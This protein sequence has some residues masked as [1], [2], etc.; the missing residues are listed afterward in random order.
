MRVVGLTGVYN[1][2]SGSYV[3]LIKS[4]YTG[5]FCYGVGLRSYFSRIHGTACACGFEDPDEAWSASQKLNIL[6]ASDDN[7]KSNRCYRYCDYL[8]DFVEVTQDG[9]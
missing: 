9:E 1:D 8:G 6:C 3:F 2:I 5:K 7:R 4:E